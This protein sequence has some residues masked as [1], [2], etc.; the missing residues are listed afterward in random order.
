MAAYAEESL[1]LALDPFPRKP[2]AVFA[3]PAEPTVLSPF[4]VLI[5]MKARR[6]P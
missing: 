1:A 6:E 4:A 2:G 5:D 3:P